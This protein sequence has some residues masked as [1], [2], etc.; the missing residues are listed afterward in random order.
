M[1]RKVIFPR[2]IL[3]SALARRIPFH[4]DGF[5]LIEILLTIFI[6]GLV[7]STVWASY[8]GTL[9]LVKELEYENDVYKMSRTTMDRIIR[10]L[11]S[12]QPV[13]G[14]FKFQAKKDYFGNREFHWLSFSSA[15]HLDFSEKE[16]GG[17]SSMIGYFIEEASGGGSFSLRRS[18][19]R[20]TNASR[21]KIKSQSFLICRNI[22]SFTFKFYDSS[23]REY[24][25]WDSTS[26]RQ[27]KQ[28]K[29][30]SAIKIELSIANV[31]DKEKPYKFMT[32]IYLP[33]RL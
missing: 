29:T 12:V 2:R 25:D 8:S 1:K 19:L 4:Q 26:S 24:D 23:G 31:V 32:K 7:L 13:G 16:I 18:D 3:A 10:D 33:V 21:E 9:T 22:Q 28:N 15:A 14:A 17:G 5:T 27:E 6:L 20:D 30:P 11:S